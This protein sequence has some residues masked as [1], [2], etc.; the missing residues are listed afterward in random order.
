MELLFGAGSEAML[1]VGAEMTSGNM[2]IIWWFE[3]DNEPLCAG[4]RLM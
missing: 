3:D 4:L 2:D 1:A